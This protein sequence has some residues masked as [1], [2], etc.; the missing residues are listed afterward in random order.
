M[1]A[2]KLT[3]AGRYERNELR[4]SYRSEHYS[5]NLTTTSEDVTLKVPKLKGI[6]FY[7]LTPFPGS[8]LPRLGVYLFS[9]SPAT[10]LHFFLGVFYILLPALTPLFLVN[11]WSRYPASVHNA[12]IAASSPIASRGDFS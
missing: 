4:Q 9:F 6:S 10:N 1:E 12:N 7:F 5:H 3:Q 11:R 8:F 2:E